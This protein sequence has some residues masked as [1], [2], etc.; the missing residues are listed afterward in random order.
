[1][2]VRVLHEGQFELQGDTMA[3]LRQLDDAWMEALRADDA[4]RFA[5]LRDEII[6]LIRSEGRPLPADTL[7][8]SDLIAPHAE[9]TIGE[10]HRMFS[11]GS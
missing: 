2:I 11:A 10:A 4:E 9:I 7:R 3:R 8:E 5:A 1:M 6:G